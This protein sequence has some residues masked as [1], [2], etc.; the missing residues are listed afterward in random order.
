LQG[1]AADQQPSMEAVCENK[2]SYY[3]TVVKIKVCSIEYIKFINWKL[4]NLEKKVYY[5][6]E[7]FLKASYLYINW[8]TLVV[9]IPLFVYYA[10]CWHLVETWSESLLLWPLITVRGFTQNTWC[11]NA[12]TELE[13]LYNV[14]S[15]MS[16]LRNFII[17]IDIKI[18]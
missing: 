12:F 9:C 5:V 17:I 10:R 15:K 14:I 13:E 18:R 3:R 11:I 2:E 1:N 8:L 6:R 4:N 7:L 16:S